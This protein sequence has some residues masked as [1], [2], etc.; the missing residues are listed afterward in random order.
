MSKTPHRSFTVRVPT[1]LYT[2]I[3]DA[4]AADGVYLNTK[5]HELLLSGLGQARS[6]NEALLRLVKKEMID[7]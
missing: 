3:A 4:A 1:E 7:E 5:V 6:L 2:K